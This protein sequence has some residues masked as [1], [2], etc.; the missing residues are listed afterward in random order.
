MARP[1]KL[2]MQ[3]M[4]PPCVQLA[5]DSRGCMLQQRASD[6][7]RDS[8][9]ALAASLACLLWDLQEHSAAASTAQRTSAL[10]ADRKP[11]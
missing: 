7:A 3:A 9:A 1:L 5:P 6:A 8:L 11:D 4:W 2:A 10:G